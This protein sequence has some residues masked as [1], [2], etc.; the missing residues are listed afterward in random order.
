LLRILLSRLYNSFIMKK[1]LAKFFILLAI[2]VWFACGQNRSAKPDATTQQQSKSTPPA[3][4]TQQ[5]P[6]AQEPQATQQNAPAAAAGFRMPAFW[7]NPDA[8][9]MLAPTLDPATVSPAARAAYVVAQKKPKLLAQMPCFC[10]CDRFGHQ[11]LH[12]CYVT[13]HAEH[14]DVCIAEAVEADQLEQQG[15]SAE[16]IRSVLVAKHHPPS[17]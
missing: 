14:C 7:E 8:A 5:Q 2:M 1:Q 9:P 12:D 16:E 15:M 6:P 4:S 17:E 10:Y 3:D 13:T 11:S